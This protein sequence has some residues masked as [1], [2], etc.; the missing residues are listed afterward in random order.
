MQKLLN[1]ITYLQLF[2]A[3]GLFLELLKSGFGKFF[4]TMAYIDVALD[5]NKFRTAVPSRANLSARPV[6]ESDIPILRSILSDPASSSVDRL[7][8]VR[9]LA[10]LTAGI[11]TCYV[12]EDSDGNVRFLQWLILPEENENL[13][14]HYGDWYPRLSP[15]EGLMES[16]YVFPLYRGTGVLAVAFG[17]IIE[18]ASRSGVKRILG[19][20]PEQNTISL[21]SFMRLGFEPYRLRIE[22]RLF[23]LRKSSTVALSL[24]DE[25]PKLKELLTPATV[26]LFRKTNALHVKEVLHTHG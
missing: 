15:G 6:R 18:T 24:R 19:M 3:N 14:S 4:G 17:K 13:R 25:E 23:G 9:R 22:K 10:M 2:L 7:E 1:I 16:G 5:V 8:I 12:V 21:A 11:K 20:I 26:G